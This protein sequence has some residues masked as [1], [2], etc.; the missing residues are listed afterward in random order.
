VAA[1]EAIGHAGFAEVQ[2]ERDGAEAAI[3]AERHQSSS[4]DCIVATV[5][6]KSRSSAGR[7]LTSNLI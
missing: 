7:V 1:A 3:E 5:R 6:K 2:P 4:P